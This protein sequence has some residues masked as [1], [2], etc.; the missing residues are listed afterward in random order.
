MSIIKSLSVGNGDMFYIKHNTDSFTTIDCCLDEDNQDAILAEIQRESARKGIT[1]F[2]STHPDEDHIHGI[3]DFETQIGIANFYCVANNATKNEETE[4]FKAYCCL[5]DSNK[6]FHL[7]TGCSR[8][9]LNQ[10]D[11]TRNSA[12]INFLWP[13]T[14]NAFFKEE[15]QK[16]SNGEAFNNL[17]PIFTYSV[18]Q[19]ACVMWMGDIESEFLENIKAEI[20]WP[21]VDIL[22]AP[23]HGRDSG[24]VPSDVLEAIDPQVIVIGEAPSLYLNYYDGYNTITQN[25]A[26]EITFDCQAG[27]IHVYVSNPNYSVYF[28][29]NRNAVNPS[30]GHYLGSLATK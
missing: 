3:G 4:S 14:A 23:H 25:S 20:E 9:W 26:G 11:N 5:R 30:L 16:A 7:K 8:K 12:G 19:G 22:F 27:W 2:I 29:R 10:D 21:Q 6:A 13:N 18:Q 28:P 15:L 17:S 24:K 1:R